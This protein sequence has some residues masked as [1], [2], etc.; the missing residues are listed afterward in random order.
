MAGAA[1]IATQLTD[2]SVVTYRLTLDGVD[3]LSRGSG[4]GVPIESI[5]VNE[6]GPGGVSSLA[7]TINDPLVEATFVS[8][9]VVEFWDVAN[10]RPE[11]LGFVQSVAVS[12]TAV[13]RVFHVT[14]VGIEALLDWMLV[15]YL[16]V[17][18]GTVLASAIQGI[19]ANA[20]GVGWPIRAFATTPAEA[21]AI[22][23]QE[24]P[25]VGN[26]GTFPVVAYEVELEGQTVREA[27]RLV[28]EAAGTWYG[29]NAGPQFTI[30]F[31]SGLR[32]GNVYLTDGQWNGQLGSDLSGL[33]IGT[34]SV[35]ATSPTALKIDLRPSDVTRGVYIKGGVP[36]TTGYDPIGSGLIAD[37]S[38]IP[39]Q[40]AYITDDTVLTDEVRNYVGVSYLGTFSMESR[41]TLT[42]DPVDPDYIDTREVR[43]GMTVT[44]DPDSQI[45]ADYTKFVLFSISKTFYPGGQK[46]DVAFGGFQRAVA[47]QTRRLTRTTRS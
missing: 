43:P 16:Q 40:V 14:C 15:P 25:M 11:F 17:F 31:Y 36:R 27:I 1:V 19:L 39:G 6:E 42:L 37:G 23:N 44:F 35:V 30:D 8:T 3:F 47:P 2:Q 5:R 28:T 12:P 45:F 21:A 32:V 18:A 10:D 38:G 34:V 22:G 26:D 29:T 24:R 9:A 4:F 7:F 46:W 13:G 33:T 41:G 20:T